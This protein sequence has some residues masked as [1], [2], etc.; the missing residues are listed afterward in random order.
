MTQTQNITN[1]HKDYLA[2][3]LQMLIN[4]LQDILRAV[5]NSGDDDVGYI[6]ECLRLMELKI[7]TLRRSISY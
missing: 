1:V 7:R 4:G 2:R 6:D 3:C 5:E